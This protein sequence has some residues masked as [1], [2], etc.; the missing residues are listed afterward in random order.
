MSK[1]IIIVRI[2]KGIIPDPSTMYPIL[3]SMYELLFLFRCMFAS[4]KNDKE[5][6]MLL[7]IWK[8]RRNNNLT[9]MSDEEQDEKNTNQRE[10]RQVLRLI[11][12]LPLY[13]NIIDCK[14]NQKTAKYSIRNQQI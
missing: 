1:G 3:R 14:Y 10:S 4:S 9:Q 6:E 2:Q 12:S 5:R 13:T 11:F 8:I 7:N